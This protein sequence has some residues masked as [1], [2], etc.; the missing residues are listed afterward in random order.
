MPGCC[1]PANPDHFQTAFGRKTVGKCYVPAAWQ[2][3]T[4]QGGTTK[5]SPTKG[6][7]TKGK[8]SGR[9]NRQQ[10]TR[11]KKGAAGGDP[12]RYDELFARRA[13]TPPQTK[14]NPTKGKPSGR[15]NR[16]QETRRKKGAAG[17][18]PC[19]YDELFAR[20]AATPPQAPPRR[21]LQRAPR[22][23]PA[24]CRDTPSLPGWTRRMWRRR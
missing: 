24:R 13:A 18:D 21:A 9:E 3:S 14:G 11:R 17:G 8:P 1:S 12:C 19:R 16:Q 6:N 5:G 7:P 23:Q 10:E 15:E 4:V 20:R 2:V 22:P